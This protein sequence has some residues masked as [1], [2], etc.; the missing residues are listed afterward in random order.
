MLKLIPQIDQIELL[1]PA[2]N[3]H[4]LSILVHGQTYCPGWDNFQLIPN[5]NRRAETKGVFEFN[6][7]ASSPG[8]NGLDEVSTR[9][10]A[11]H[12]FP[13]GCFVREVKVSAAANTVHALLVNGIS[14]NYNQQ[15]AAG[16]VNTCK[17]PYSV[18]YSDNNDFKEA[19]KNAVNNFSDPRY[20]RSAYI[21]GV[22]LIKKGL[23]RNKRQQQKMYIIIEG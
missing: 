9:V 12:V 6:F 3:S 5:R 20:I 1:P 10:S 4:S 7:S 23:L 21:N 17:R 8:F 18:G 11:M 19:V 22:R 15:A 2:N 14:V 13:P 16:K